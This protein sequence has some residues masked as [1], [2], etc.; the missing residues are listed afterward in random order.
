MIRKV[1]AVRFT[2]MKAYSAIYGFVRKHATS[3]R[4][5]IA[6]AQAFGLLSFFFVVNDA[7]VQTI[8]LM[9]LYVS[10]QA[11]SAF[12]LLAIQFSSKRG[13]VLSFRF[14]GFLCIYFGIVFQCFSG[15]TGAGFGHELITVAVFLI[16][17][18]IQLTV[19]ALARYKLLLVLQLLFAATLPF[20]VLYPISVISIFTLLLLIL[21]IKLDLN[22][23]F[24]STKF[25]RDDISDWSYSLCMQSPF[26]LYPFFDPLL[27]NRIDIELYGQYLIFGKFIFGITNFIFSFF[28][29]RLIKGERLQIEKLPYLIFVIVLASLLM[30]LSSIPLYLYV[31][32]LALVVNMG[33]LYIRGSLKSCRAPHLLVSIV[34]I[35]IYFAGLLYFSDGFF[36]AE[37]IYF[38][39]FLIIC[40]S[41]SVLTVWFSIKFRNST[42]S[43]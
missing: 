6:S 15:Y 13:S 12:L 37:N 14:I 29:F 24:R 18:L 27:S 1:K 4:L 3:E 32:C 38:V 17:G 35:A 30:T 26:I 39:P 34:S 36:T 25:S 11:A 42:I 2:D 22:S 33:S 9:S 8:K 10:S 43:R 28:Q 7:S 19:T 16:V 31:L 5:L 20:V 23:I 21:F 41:F 40:I